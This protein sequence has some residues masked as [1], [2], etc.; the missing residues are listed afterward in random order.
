L[1]YTD[2]DSNEDVDIM[3]EEMASA[4][5]E[6]LKSVT[7]PRLSAHEQIQL[8]D[9][10]ECV[11]VVEKQRRSMDDNATR[12]MLSFRQQTLRKGRAHDLNL[13]WR[14]ISW[15]FHSNSQDI[16]VD[17][18]SRQF[19]SRLT[20]ADARETGLCMWITDP[21]VL[22]SRRKSFDHNCLCQVRRVN[23][24]QLRGTNIQRVI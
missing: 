10:I 1:S 16:L 11:A 17:M 18:A 12:F 9:I 19:H 24:R 6:K 7:I 13:S 5:S 15:A 22:V 14:D 2:F 20:W 3:T 23:S 21:N 4:T 8:A